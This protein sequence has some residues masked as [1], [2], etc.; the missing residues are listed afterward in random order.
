MLHLK[1]LTEMSQYI[2]PPS[3]PRR[4]MCFSI[5]FS[6]DFWQCIRLI[7]KGHVYILVVLLT[8]INKVTFGECNCKLYVL[9]GNTMM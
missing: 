5:I 4:Y 3:K 1:P 7:S 9:N 2:F 6:A 8:P